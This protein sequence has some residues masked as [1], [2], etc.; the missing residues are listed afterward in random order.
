MLKSSLFL[1]SFAAVILSG[2]APAPVYR[3]KSNPDYVRSAKANSEK[4]ADNPDK[5]P[6]AVA[7][8]IASYYGKEFHGRKTANGETF[9]MNALTAAHRTLP[10]GTMVK[11]TNLAN[12]KEVT[13]RI[14]DRGPFIKGRIIDLSY[15][16]AA[17]ID[18]LSVG[19]VKLEII[20]Y[21][22]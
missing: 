13:V 14:N 6:L 19:Q 20:K 5:W 10:F 11:V 1:I 4:K 7:T 2:C 21:P 22:K 18:L 3:T 17:V 15:G 8:G 12:N 9:D 16:A